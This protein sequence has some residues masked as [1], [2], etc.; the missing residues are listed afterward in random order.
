MIKQIIH[1]ADIHIPN[2][3][4][5]RPYGEMIHAF[6][7]T[8]ISDFKENGWRSEET[9]IVLAGDIFEDKIKS[10]NESKAMLHDMLNFLDQIAV[11][12][13]IAGNH[14]MLEK[15]HD[16]MDSLMP[17]FSINGAYQ[18]VHY[19]DKELGFQSGYIVDDDTAFA[20]YS[21]Y[22]SYAKP[23]LLGI[24]DKEH[25]R[26]VVG[27]FHG[28]MPG[29]TT[30]AGRMSDKGVDPDIFKECDCVMAGH[31]HKYQTIKKNGVPVVYAG[32]LFQKDC[33]ENVSMH[34]YVVW[35]METLEYR[36]REVPNDYRSFKFTISDY[37]DIKN[38]T[39]KILNL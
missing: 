1:V 5:N 32:S 10:N 27:L 33:G 23:D 11:T 2:N 3:E 8:L 22:T 28:D 19:L 13:V 36:H 14:D 9:R 31:I 15:N 4:K 29:T 26:N 35:D 24:R 17:T 21:I 37:D 30:D 6:L 12:Y 16:R 20:L 25:V 39:E 7:K 38:D 34:G 18:N